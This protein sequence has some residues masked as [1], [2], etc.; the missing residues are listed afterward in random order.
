MSFKKFKILTMKKMISKRISKGAKKTKTKAELIMLR[1]TL[2]AGG[3]PSQCGLH[4]DHIT[5]FTL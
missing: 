2:V 5:T 1:V 3:R 4:P